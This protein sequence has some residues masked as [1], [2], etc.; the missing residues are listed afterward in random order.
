LGKDFVQTI[1]ARQSTAYEGIDF[2]DAILKTILVPSM[3]DYKLDNL[4]TISTHNLN[5]DVFVQL[6][7]GPW[8]MPGDELQ[9]IGIED[10]RLLE[11]G[12][13]SATKSTE[14]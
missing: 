9:M 6:S 2:K 10:Q 11:S 14:L 1:H 4:V 7:T 13:Q 12:S 5:G 3:L 8:H